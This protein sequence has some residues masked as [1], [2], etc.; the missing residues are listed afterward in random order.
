M[1]N[2]VFRFGS[3]EP[4]Y[5]GRSQSAESRGQ[6]EM[7]NKVCFGNDGQRIQRAV[8]DREKRGEPRVKTL[9]PAGYVGIPDVHR[10]FKDQEFNDKSVQPRSG[11]ERWLSR[12]GAGQWEKRRNE[13]M[14]E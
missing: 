11:A 14:K 12:S 5:P 9:L 4:E 7:Q 2:K 6:R 13:G 10:R 1:Q 8:K 3:A